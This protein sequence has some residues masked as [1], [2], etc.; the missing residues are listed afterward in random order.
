ML[1]DVL[2]HAGTRIDNCEPHT[3]TTQFV[4]FIGR[5]IVG[6][7]CDCAATWHCISRI[8]GQ[9][10]HDQLELTGVDMHRP[11]VIRKLQL[12]SSLLTEAAV[13]QLSHASQLTSEI[14]DVRLQ[15]LPSGKRE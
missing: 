4:A 1:L 5:T 15:R 10:Q 2:T 7:D 12:D 13:Q 6:A 8:Y 3:V 11:Q 9:I 14:D